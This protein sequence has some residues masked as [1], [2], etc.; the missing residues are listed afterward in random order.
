MSEDKPKRQLTQEQLKKLADAR[1]KALE[2]RK[3]KALVNKAEKLEKAKAL[4]ENYKKVIGQVEVKPVQTPQTESILDTEPKQEPKQESKKV[5]QVTKSK[6]KKVLKPASDESS[7]DSSDDSEYDATEIAH[8]YRQ[9][10]KTKYEA[11]YRNVQTHNP[12]LT[13]PYQ[14]AFMIAKHNLQGKVSNEIKKIAYG[15][16]FG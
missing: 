3:K 5:Q 6:V 12:C 2:V 16:L 7:S 11:K 14:D 8:K 10:Y 9:K 4:D 1:A 15:S 13:T